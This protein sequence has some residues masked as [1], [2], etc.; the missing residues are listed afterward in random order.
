MFGSNPHFR[1]M[2]ELNFERCARVWEDVRYRHRGYS[3]ANIVST[4]PSRSNYWIERRTV[5]HP[6]TGN[7][8]TCYALQ[9]YNT[10]I[11]AWW[12]DGTC[13]TRAW[14]SAI[15]RSVTTQFGPVSIWSD[16]RC[17]FQDRVR[18]GGHRVSYPYGDG[19]TIPPDGVLTGLIDY[20]RR[21]IPARKK[22]RLQLVREFR[23]YATPR[24]L[25]GEFDCFVSRLPFSRR[26]KEELFYAFATNAGHEKIQSC[27]TDPKGRASGPQPTTMLR[28]A[29]DGIIAAAMSQDEWYE[30]YPIE[31]GPVNVREL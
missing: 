15:T 26:S 28:A 31:Y 16:S 9:M 27:L 7:V 21:I 19:L 29:F 1:I 8:E 17:G 10:Y 18:F 25:L 20:R 12:Q 22:E 30:S 24:V 5:S 3:G 23:K 6:L 4:N 2:G 13:Q 11:L 14:G